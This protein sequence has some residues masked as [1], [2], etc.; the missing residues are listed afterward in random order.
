MVKA[1]NFKVGDKI[2]RHSTSYGLLQVPVAG[3]VTR[4]GLGLATVT[5][6]KRTGKYGSLSGGSMAMP[7][8][9]VMKLAELV[10]EHRKVSR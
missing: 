2:E 10:S 9:R 4:I 7:R 1:S 6:E 5:Y 8:K 3:V